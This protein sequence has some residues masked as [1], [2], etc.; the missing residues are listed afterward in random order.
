[1]HFI[2]LIAACNILSVV[3]NKFASIII[4]IIIIIPN[5]GS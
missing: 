2:T 1:M 4:I 3:H 5:L